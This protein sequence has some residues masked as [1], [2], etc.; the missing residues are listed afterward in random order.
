MTTLGGYNVGDRVWICGTGWWRRGV[1][2]ACLRTKI[3]VRYPLRGGGHRDKRLNPGDPAVQP[4]RFRPDI[5]ADLVEHDQLPA[6]L[7]R[8]IAKIGAWDAAS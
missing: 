8:P 5:A 2:H 4:D 7:D 3:I 6:H 1:V